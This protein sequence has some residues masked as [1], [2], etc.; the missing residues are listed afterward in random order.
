MSK[1]FSLGID[2]SCYTTSVGIM[3]IEDSEIVENIKI[4]LKVKNGMRG[5]RQSEGFYQHVINL[6]DIFEKIPRKILSNLEYVVVSEK[7]RDVEGSYMPVFNAGLSFAKALS[8]T[9]N[10]K[11]LKTSH[12]IGHILS[13]LIE[14]DLDKNS[15]FLSIHMSGGTT[16]ILKTSIEGCLL[17]NEIIGG[18]KDIS[19]GQLIDRIGVKMGFGFPC[20]K[21]MESTILNHKEN[22]IEELKF[23]ISVDKGYI[24]FS[25]SESY[26]Y[27]YIKDG[28]KKEDIIYSLFKGISI[29]LLKGIESLPDYGLNQIL[30]TGGVSAND[31][32]FNYIKSNSNKKVFRPQKPLCT[33]NGVGLSYYPIFKN[34]LE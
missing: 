5:L 9:A 19:A 20:G 4:P 22:N 12:Q 30:L 2:T 6:G 14:N 25:G 7:P 10:S 11:I 15:S 21:D 1:S 16:E 27:G 32:I 13:G 31:F 3:S 33:D 34:N 26:G 17:N 18:T 24:N 23:P 8:S 29:S 28:H